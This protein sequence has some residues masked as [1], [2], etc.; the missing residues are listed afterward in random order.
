MVSDIFDTIVLPSADID[1]SGKVTN[2]NP[3]TTDIVAR[4][5]TVTNIQNANQ[6]RLKAYFNTPFGPDGTTQE[7]V[8]FYDSYDVLLQL[9]VQAE[10][11]L[12]IDLEG[13]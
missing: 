4:N 12:E 2:P 13:E 8:K 10:V 6:I 11:L 1:G 5:Q 7:D 3:K 9:G